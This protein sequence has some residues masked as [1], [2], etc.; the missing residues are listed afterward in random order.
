MSIELKLTTSQIVI[1]LIKHKHFDYTLEPVLL[2]LA[3][4]NSLIGIQAM[5]VKAL[6][7]ITYTKCCVLGFD[8]LHVNL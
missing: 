3:P 1:N 5:I 2:N 8:S 7:E 4:L 6:P